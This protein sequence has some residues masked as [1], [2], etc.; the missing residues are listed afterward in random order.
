MK[1]GILGAGL[2]GLTLASMLKHDV[3]LLEKAGACGG[4][5]RS[6]QDAGYTFD[7]G[8]GH[9]IFSKDQQVLGFMNGLV[10]NGVVQNRRNTKILYKGKYVKYP[11]ENG[12][13][14]LPE[15]DALECL[16]HF[17]AAVQAK[18]AGVQPVPSNFEEWMY[19][20]FG[21]GITEKYLIPY[22]RKIWNFPP[23]GMAADWVADRIP[24]PPVEDV[25][26]SFLKL[27]TE[28]YTHQLNFFY[29]S[30]G[31]IQSI[32][33]TLGSG[34]SGRIRCNASITRIAKKD[35]WLVH[36]DGLVDEYDRLVS[37]I[38]VMELLDYLEDVPA[39][40]MDAARGLKFNS[41]INVLIGVD[42]PKMND[43][44]WVYIPEDD[45]DFN[46][47]IFLSN[48][49]PGM[50]PAGKSSVAVE[51][52]CQFGDEIWSK[53]DDVILK[54]IIAGLERKGVL[55]TSEV[56]YSKVVRSKYAYVIYDLDYNRNIKTVTDFLASIGI[57]ICGRFS[58][59]K[60]LNMD[61]CI[62]SA[63]RMAKKLNGASA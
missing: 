29:P 18:K 47:L 50:A 16:M 2:T 52:T 46:R 37:T 44:H 33:D 19:Q 49:A 8:G 31:G 30:T 54:E 24:Q 55:K 38:P 13:G 21:K 5:C 57:E 40:V 60:Y 10:R 42:S 6:V 22:N 63:M 56:C 26:K 12:L 45:V 62:M 34:M 15:D 4:L 43:F 11:F 61:A 36:H 3:E 17:L 14:E 25:I 48:Y 9:I 53:P 32:I 1:V 20:T 28:G 7:V 35:R 23:S 58:E 39:D 41:L 59:F 51:L 27:E